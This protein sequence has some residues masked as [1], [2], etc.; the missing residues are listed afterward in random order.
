MRD[1]AFYFAVARSPCPPSRFKRPRE[2]Q[3]ISYLEASDREG[4]EQ[5]QIMED[6]E[7]IAG[8]EAVIRRHAEI[9]AVLHGELQRIGAEVHQVQTQNDSI[10]RMFQALNVIKDDFNMAGASDETSR[11]RRMVEIGHRL[12]KNLNEPKEQQAPQPKPHPLPPQMPR[13]RGRPPLHGNT[14]TPA[15]TVAAAAR[16]I[17]TPPAS[18]P[19]ESQIAAASLTLSSG[20]PAVALLSLLE[21]ALAARA[22]PQ[23]QPQSQSQPG[24]ASQTLMPPPPP[25]APAAV[26]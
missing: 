25:V 15:A 17:F 1:G 12:V 8:I 4:A 20:D 19:V 7:H 5:T 13:G 14:Q 3:D 16:P 11:K 22:P 26:E 24:P 21:K 9:N 10:K 18:F 23:S 6:L 2:E